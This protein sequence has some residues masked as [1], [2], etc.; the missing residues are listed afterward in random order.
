MLSNPRLVSRPHKTNE[1]ALNE[2]L[3]KFRITNLE[4]IKRIGSKREPILF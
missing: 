4:I 2:V 3:K 1:H